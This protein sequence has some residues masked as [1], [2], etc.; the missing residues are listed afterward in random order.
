MVMFRKSVLLSAALLA[1]FGASQITTAQFGGWFDG[2]VLETIQTP[3]VQAKLAKR[4]VQREHARQNDKPIP[5]SDFVLVDVRS[6]IEI[7]VSVIPGAI[8]KA[9]YEKNPEKYKDKTV[10]AY[11]TVGGR[12]ARYAKQLQE[13]GVMAINYKGSV[14]GWVKAGLPLVTLDGEPTHRV[15]VFSDR[16]QVPSKYEAIA[17]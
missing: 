16:Y 1:I 11:C 9:V 2:P 10:I 3:G 15:H 13:S 14:L 6:D 8:T 17:N 7:Q 5:E 4:N 12:S